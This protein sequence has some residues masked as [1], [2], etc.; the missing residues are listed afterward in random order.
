MA[1]ILWYIQ[2]QIWMWNSSEGQGTDLEVVSLLGSTEALG[3]DEICR[4]GYVMRKE[5]LRQYLGK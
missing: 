1:Y 4:G 5:D 2:L 3:M